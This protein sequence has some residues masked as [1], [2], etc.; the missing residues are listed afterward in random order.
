MKIKLEAVESDLSVGNVVEYEIV[1][2]VYDNHLNLIKNIYE[3][4]LEG[5][6]NEGK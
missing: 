5:K 2:N 4:F 6:I 3:H 1:E